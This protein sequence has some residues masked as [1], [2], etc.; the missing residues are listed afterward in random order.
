MIVFRVDGNE[1][2]GIGHIMRCL[3]IAEALRCRNQEIVFVLSD[4]RCVSLISQKQFKYEILNENYSTMDSGMN[5]FIKIIDMY[6]PSVVVVDSYYVTYDFLSALR[7]FVIV[8]YLDDLL[9]YDYPVDILINYNI[10]S[11]LND[12]RTLYKN[13]ETEPKYLLGP[14]YV[15]LRSEFTNCS[16]RNAIRDVKNILVSTGGADPE[17]VATSM[18]SY[19]RNNF[20]KYEKFTFTFV[21]GSNN[22]HFERIH[23][24]ASELP[25]VELRVNEKNMS[26]LMRKCDL[27]I[28]AAGSTL[29]EL[30]VCGVPTIT[31]VL[32]DNQIR[33]ANAFFDRGVMSYIGDVRVEE[34]YLERMFGL[35]NILS[36]KQAI[37]EAMISEGYKAVGACGAD[38]IAES[39]IEFLG[40]GC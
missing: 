36:D 7:S 29:Y 33:A 24:L 37:R 13:S 23:S 10:Y 3:S 18:L 1:K 20:E 22:Q 27:A 26:G 25:N 4:D 40:G 6:K 11:E 8:A 16:K 28:S 35:I 2:I 19:I 15:P 5:T 30:C 14:K 34:D 31:Y 38:N 21:V 9:L 32:A 17:N 39:L 12:Y